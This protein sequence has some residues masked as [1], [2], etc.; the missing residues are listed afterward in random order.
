MD[1]RSKLAIIWLV[2]GFLEIVFAHLFIARKQDPFADP[3]SWLAAKWIKPV[4]NVQTMTNAAMDAGLMSREW[5]VG[6]TVRMMTQ[7]GLGVMLLGGLLFVHPWSTTVAI[8]ISVVWIVATMA[9][10]IV[11]FVM[12]CIRL[13][14]EG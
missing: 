6:F 5:Y 4:K 2:T 13:S 9:V 3:N 14:K 7:M 8:I 12:K 11:S 10:F 1:T